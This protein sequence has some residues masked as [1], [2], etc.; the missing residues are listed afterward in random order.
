VENFVRPARGQDDEPQS[1]RR[2]FGKESFI[3]QMGRPGRRVLRICDPRSGNVIW[4][5]PFPQAR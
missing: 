3:K 1:P 5:K 4:G 2:W